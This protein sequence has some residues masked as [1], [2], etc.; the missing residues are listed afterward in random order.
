MTTTSTG[1]RLA[2]CHDL[3]QDRRRAQ[4]RLRGEEEGE[5]PVDADEHSAEDE[6]HVDQGQADD[7][8]VECFFEIFLAENYHADHVPWSEQNNCQ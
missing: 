4:L 5:R 8:L 6:D 2:S 7:Q 3:K 1:C